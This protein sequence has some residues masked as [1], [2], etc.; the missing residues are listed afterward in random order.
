MSNE[1]KDDPGALKLAI[2]A[3]VIAET[4][5]PNLT[6]QAAVDAVAR[7]LQPM[8]ESASAVADEP[9]QR[10]IA[11]VYETFQVHIDIMRQQ[12]Q[13]AIDLAVAAKEVAAELEEQRDAAIEAHED[14]IDALQDHDTR[15]PIVSQ[16]FESIVEMVHDGMQIDGYYSQCI[17]CDLLERIGEVNHD[18]AETL[19]EC[20]VGDGLMYVPK[21]QAEKLEL[22]L[23]DFIRTFSDAYAAARIDRIGVA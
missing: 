18:E 23:R 12:G 3:Q 10:A 17:A 21:A 7:V 11:E 8:W 5:D 14:L 22:M 2:V 4:G 1:F 15:H 6:A 9:Q 16:V 19:M 20:L 13:Q